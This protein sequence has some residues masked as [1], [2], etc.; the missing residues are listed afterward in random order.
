MALILQKGHVALLPVVVLHAIYTSLAKGLFA[1]IYCY[2]ID[3]LQ[4]TNRTSHK[5]KCSHQSRLTVS[6]LTL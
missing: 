2:W 3:K 4:I 6:N 5:K 1:A